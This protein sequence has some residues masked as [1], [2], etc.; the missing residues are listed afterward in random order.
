MTFGPRKQPGPNLEVFSDSN[1]GDMK[2]IRVLATSGTLVTYRGRPIA[3]K[4][5]RQPRSTR[6]THSAEL[7]ALDQSARM[8]L[9]AR[10]LLKEMNL[11][12]TEPTPIYVDNEALAFT[13]IAEHMTDANRHMHT[14]YFAVCDDVANKDLS[15]L[16]MRGTHNP[17]DALTKALGYEVFNRH[18]DY[19][20]YETQPPDAPKPSGRGGELGIKYIDLPDDYL[21]TGRTCKG[22]PKGPV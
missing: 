9:A 16:W 5:K 6:S 20:L 13:A 21:A 7:I 18:N 3:W 11:G 22:E 2:E 10:Y 17:A 12:S 19:M 1:F 4:S 14:K 15:V 8:A